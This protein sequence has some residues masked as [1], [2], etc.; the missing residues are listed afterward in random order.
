MEPLSC[1]LHGLERLDIETA[2]RV[3]ILGAGPIG[4]LL[5]QGLRLNGAAEVVAVDKNPDRPPWPSPWA[6]T[7]A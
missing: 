7:A 1:V 2:A 3:A 6:P 4:L 5:L